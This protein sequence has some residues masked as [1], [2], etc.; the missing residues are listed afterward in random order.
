MDSGWWRGQCLA[1]AVGLVVSSSV[2][3][4]IGGS[5]LTGIVVD[6][7]GAAVPG[8][9][10][11]ITSAETN[12]RRTTLTSGDGTYVVPG[13]VPGSYSV[14]VELNGF[15]PLTRE[16]I[17]L[18]TGET[19]RLDLRLELG[20]VTE[21]ITVTAGA[22]VLRSETSGLGHLVDN[23]KIIQLPLNGR[24]FITLA[25][26]VPGVAVPPSPAAPF[27]RINGGR[28]RTNEYLFDG[29]SVLQPE[30]GQVAF[31]PNL[32]AIQEFKIESNSPPAEFGRFNGGVVN[33]TTRSGTNALHGTAFEFFRHEAL[34]ARNFFAPTSAVEPQFRRNQFGGV[35]GGPLRR[36]RTFFFVDYQGQRQTIGRTAIST[37]PTLLQRQGVFTE[38][39]GGR[40]PAI[41]DPATGGA[42][43][44]PFAGNTIPR[45]RM[46]PVARALLER[47]PLPTST[48]TANN[49]R[50]VADESVEQDQFSLRLDHRFPANRDQVFGRLT[51]FREEFLPVTPFSDGSGVT[52][53]TLGPQDTTSSSFASSYQRTFSSDVL[54]ELRIGDTR[55]AVVR[56]AASLG[57]TASTSLGLPGI[58]SNARFPNTLPTFLIA[59]YQ[60]LGSPPNTASEF[61]TSVTQIADSLTWLKGRHVFKMGGD[62]RW[63]RLDVL[64]PPS[65]TGS[66]T[67]SSLFSDLPGVA[68]TGTPLASFLLGQVQQ[69]SID[70]QKE[71]IRNRAHFEEYFVQDDWRLSD[72]VTVNGGVRYTLNFPSTEQNDQ[73][74]VFNLETQQLE[75]LG[76][77]GQPRAAR[78]L[79]K[80]NLGPRLGIVGRITDRTVARTGYGMVWIEM[81]GITTPFTT[82]VFPFLQTV[83]QRTL[84]NINPAFVLAGGP[85]VQPIAL[86]PDAGVGQG[87]F[88]VDRDLSSGYVQQWHTSVQHALTADAS[89]EVAYTGS[90][91]TRVGVPDTNLNQLTV[92]QLAQG[93]SL[94]QRVPNPYFGV[95]P[96]SSSLGDP[97]IPVAQ[98]LKPF[99]QYTTVSLYRNNVGTTIY[100]GVYAK[101]EQRF[102]RGL[103]YLVSYTRSKLVDDASSVFDASILTGPVANFPVADS[104]NRRLER[105]YSSGDIPHVFVASGVWDMAWGFTLTGIVTLQSGV[106]L[107]IAQTTNNNAFAGFGTQRPNLVGDPELPGDERSVARWFNTS[108]F[109]P[110]P[111][112]TI[113]TSSRNP[114]R[115]PSY[116]NL[117]LALMRRVALPG[118]RAL[119][120]RAE[121]FNA[122]N[123]PPL[124][125]PNTT[126]GSASFG[127]ITSAGDPRVVQLAVKFIF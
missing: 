118:S 3:A 61:S 89:V 106:P 10:L 68:N 87:V 46:D 110:A 126:V 72:R 47:Y 17:L 54:N 85:S 19:L 116:R 102:S 82:P 25:T 24:S 75:Y 53:G 29:I 79:H 42:G 8:A 112:F 123:T 70:L 83:S 127:T 12:L 26:L 56:S 114:V 21:A 31:F 58:P 59:G 57:G 115:G 20:A 78:Q 84:D 77:E 50:R 95:I 81:A 4:Q 92:D 39:I 107:A 69:F 100:H 125:A 51:R 49:Y 90:K 32:D 120:L 96:R 63:E 103:S 28:P 9:M 62:L 119:E 45:E 15:R 66:F 23:R 67:F 99:P 105:D 88:A 30:P 71:E 73:V 35:L 109:T 91:I 60:Q 52:T 104:F 101:L 40:V 16:G 36:D 76:R 48:G 7:A 55:R 93:T 13:L 98:L 22:P 37:V 38:A 14:R 11:T 41:Y 34:N 5:A 121:V 113:G 108:A 2:A 64:Q 6:Q 97:T 65:P 86:T 94:Q 27:P 44:S 43:R 124:G 1:A 74:A 111:A 122:T 33:L 18:A 117:D 80:L